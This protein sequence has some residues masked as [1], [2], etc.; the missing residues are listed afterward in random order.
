MLE[1]G[2]G[3]VSINVAL[4]LLLSGRLAEKMA[5]RMFRVVRV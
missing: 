3:K 2:D 5:R 4:D 1:E